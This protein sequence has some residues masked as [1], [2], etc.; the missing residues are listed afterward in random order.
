M[1]TCFEFYLTVCLTYLYNIQNKNI[2]IN[3]LKKPTT[4][5]IIHIRFPTIPA[6]AV[7]SLV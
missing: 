6:A 5:P 1:Y 4:V 7:T 3:G 2:D